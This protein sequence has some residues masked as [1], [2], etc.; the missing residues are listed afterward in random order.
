MPWFIQ[1]RDCDVEE[2]T[3]ADFEEDT[4]PDQAEFLGPQN[5]DHVQYS[6]QM[7]KLVRISMGNRKCQ[8][9]LS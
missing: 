4:L 3:V 1:D 6:I 9:Q 5:N 2:L 8:H 7:A